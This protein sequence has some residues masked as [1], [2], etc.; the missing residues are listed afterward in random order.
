MSVSY[1]Q[2]QR[3]LNQQQLWEN[4]RILQD[5]KW[6]DLIVGKQPQYILERVV[7][8]LFFTALF[9]LFISGLLRWLAQNQFVFFLFCFLAMI[10]LYHILQQYEARPINERGRSQVANKQRKVVQIKSKPQR[11]RKDWRQR[12][13]SEL[14]C[15]AWEALV[16]S[17]LQEWVYDTW[18][19]VLTPDKEF[20]AAIRQ[21]LNDLFG[22]LCE[23]VKRID[24][25]ELLI[26]DLLQL[27]S[28]QLQIYREVRATIGENRLQAMK[29]PARER[30]M[31]QELLTEG[32]L[33]HAL[34][35]RDS[36]YKYLSYLS[37]A[38]L[39]QVLSW[40]DASSE[41]VTIV[42]RELLASCVL[43]PLVWTFS[44]Y[45]LNKL[46]LQTF[47]SPN[48]LR[49]GR[50]QSTQQVGSKTEEQ[51][52]V[53]IFEERF[54]KSIK[55]EEKAMSAGASTL[56]T[57]SKQRSKDLS[58]GVLQK[59]KSVDSSMNQQLT[60]AA[61]KVNNVINT[62]SSVRS[63]PQHSTKS[64]CSEGDDQSPMA[65]ASNQGDEDAS[66]YSNSS[67]LPI[68]FGTK[69][70]FVG[71][72]R[73]KVATSEI[74]FGGNSKRKTFVAFG[75]RV[76]DD[77]GE[78]SVTRRFRNFEDLDAA[79]RRCSPRKYAQR[80][81]EFSKMYKLPRK[82]IF[83]PHI[84]DA[85][86]EQ[87]RQGLNTYLE[88]LIK[89][90]ELSQTQ[91]V[92]EFFNPNSTMYLLD[93]DV[94]FLRS[95]GFGS[96]KSS[97]GNRRALSRT[98]SRPMS[99]N[100]DEYQVTGRQ[101]ITVD[102]D[103]RPLT[104]VPVPDQTTQVVQ[105]PEGKDELSLSLIWK[106]S[107]DLEIRPK[108]VRHAHRR[109][110]SQGNT[111]ALGAENSELENSV[112]FSS[113]KN[114]SS[115]MD[116]DDNSAVDESESSG[117]L[118]DSEDTLLV[119]QSF[120]W[121]IDTL[122][123]LHARGI[124]KTFN[125]IMMQFFQIVAADGVDAWVMSWISNLRSEHFVARSVNQLRLLLWPGGTWFQYLPP[126]IDP[127]KPYYL[128]PTRPDHVTPETFMHMNIDSYEANRLALL[129]K[130]VIS[131]KVPERLVTVIGRQAVTSGLKDL[132]Q[133]MQSETFMSQVAYCA[134]D[135]LA[136][137]LFPELEQVLED[138]P[139][140]LKGKSGRY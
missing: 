124:R 35:N 27:V 125:S 26:S 16:G 114:R 34:E 139:N 71:K 92:W 130:E 89:D 57:A 94:G 128:P 54:R 40:E 132:Y 31:R 64:S 137:E 108:R 107:Q 47:G 123:Q 15:V 24:I 20:P 96:N 119:V 133:L 61:L 30:A 134:L 85:K 51:H 106:Q 7:H 93:I 41:I 131:T 122:F 25:K 126:H 95:L 59:V 62:T 113:L 68:D 3:I 77:Q 97:N 29:P 22:Q 18:Y 63:L 14:V 117:I 88:A 109:S 74:R 42:G 58:T 44:P 84:S 118:D 70:S 28:S 127:T 82:L 43:R 56:T 65:G 86:V 8:K 78:W 53:F 32:N 110:F 11:K 100:Q 37:D 112:V 101:P 135:R 50:Q 39:S 138:M 102:L 6:S 120:V 111:T 104:D 2:G 13:G 45:Q 17:I 121:F 23:R 73:A 48:D 76:G 140:K 4:L 49:D 55:Q 66:R 1:S 105:E 129:V 75:I 87:R 72:P 98:P 36:Q 9:A 60:A 46:F 136:G 99:P 115:E 12:A 81:E 79:L 21:L 38:L 90:K 83:S 52:G 19:G 80:Y 69:S 91:E 116:G 10:V 103:M 67:T 33:H 5:R